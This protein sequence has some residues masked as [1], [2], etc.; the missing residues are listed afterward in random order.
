MK[1]TRLPCCEDHVTGWIRTFRGANCTV[2]AEMSS[3]GL[4]VPGGGIPILVTRRAWKDGRFLQAVGAL[5]CGPTAP[6]WWS[7]WRACPQGGV[8]AE[9]C[10]AVGAVL[11]SAAL[12]LSPGSRQ[13]LPF[14]R[15]HLDII[16]LIRPQLCSVPGV[17][18]RKEIWENKPSDLERSQVFPAAW[19]GSALFPRP[20][21][22]PIPSQR[23]P[24][25]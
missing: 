21:S 6:L 10:G 17:L 19:S 7:P 23:C 8:A 18:D 20:A 11:H 24:P 13:L 5:D 14:Y 25:V 2:L 15:C 3:L 16:Q 1:S 4:G 9:P 12:V 22:S